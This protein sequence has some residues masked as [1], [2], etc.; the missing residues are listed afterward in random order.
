[1]LLYGANDGHFL[2]VAEPVDRFELCV[3]IPVAARKIVQHISQGLQSKP[4]QSLRRARTN[5]LHNSERGV[6]GA[7]LHWGG[8]GGSGTM[9]L[10]A[11]KLQPRQ[12]LPRWFLL[13]PLSVSSSPMAFTSTRFTQWFLAWLGFK[14]D[15]G[16]KPDS[17]RW[18]ASP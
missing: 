8:P 6:E 12:A 4:C 9:A 11:L 2:A 5:A 10:L 17:L 18:N 1:M 14:G 13:P 3:I 15:S 16:G 7:R